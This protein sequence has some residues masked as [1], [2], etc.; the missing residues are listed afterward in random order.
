MQTLFLLSDSQW[1]EVKTILEPKERKRRNKLQVV[2][3]GIIYLLQNGCNWEGLPPAYGNYKSVW[4]YYNKWMVFGVLEKLLFTLNEKLRLEQGRAG[5]PSLVIVD[6][7]SVKT[8]AF[9]GEET[10]YDAGKADP[11][12]LLKYLMN[13]HKMKAVDLA[14]LFRVGEGLV[15]DMLHYKKG[16]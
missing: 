7:Q 16:W 4:Y 3:S 14:K 8:P 11:I 10:G 15:S 5:Q 9:S 13:E 6:S 12:E 2:V 1:D